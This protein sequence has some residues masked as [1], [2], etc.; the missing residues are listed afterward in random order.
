MCFLFIGCERSLKNEVKNDEPKNSLLITEEEEQSGQEPNEADLVPE[1]DSWKEP[2]AKKL[3]TEFYEFYNNMKNDDI[4]R[5]SKFDYDNKNGKTDFSR[6]MAIDRRIA[7]LGVYRKYVPEK[8][9]EFIESLKLV[10]NF[11][12]THRFSVAYTNSGLRII[13]L[14]QG[15]VVSSIQYEPL[16]DQIRR[17]EQETEFFLKMRDSG[18]YLCDIYIENLR[19][20]QENF[21][22]DVQLFSSNGP[23]EPFAFVRPIVTNVS[24]EGLNMLAKYNRTLH[25]GSGIFHTDH[26]YLFASENHCDMIKITMEDDESIV[27][28]ESSQYN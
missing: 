19:D 1:D 13:S 28:N 15:V 11:G 18:Y 5:R 3:L 6:A 23:D 17:N 8:D 24:E 27:L 14:K 26:W 20:Q 25:H 12:L 10:K 22:L 21:K 4:V 2:I 7:L 9:L 16:C